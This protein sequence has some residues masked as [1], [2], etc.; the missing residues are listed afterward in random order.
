MLCDILS[1]INWHVNGLKSSY[2]DAK[3]SEVIPIRC[4]S[5]LSKLSV[6]LK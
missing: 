1:D 6:I 5:L 4:T 3:N 2:L